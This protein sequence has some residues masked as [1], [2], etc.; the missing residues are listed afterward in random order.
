MKS[1]SRLLE[2]C[3]RPQAWNGINSVLRVGISARRR[4]QRPRLMLE[5]LEMRLA[6]A[7]FTVC[8]TLDDGSTH[9][10]RWAITQ[11]NADTD[12]TSLINFNIAASGVQ[13][14]LVG[15]SS[16]YA[17]QALPALTHPTT[18]DGTTEPGFATA[19]TPVIVLNGSQAGAVDG[20]DITG[21]NSTIKGL[22]I[23]QFQGSGLVLET[24]G[25]DRIQ[26]NYIGTNA[27]GTVALANTNG[28]A[29]YSNANTIGGTSAGAGN[30][31]SGNNNV[32]VGI[33]AA[34]ASGNLVQGNYIGTNASGTSAVPNAAYGVL[35]LAASGN[36][37]GGAVAGSGNVVSGN[38][39]IGVFLAGTGTTG[40]VVAGNDIG[41]NPNGTAALANAVYGVVIN[42]GASGNL[43]GGTTSG[44]GNVVSA[45]GQVGVFLSGTGTTGN[46][47]AGNDI[48]TNLNGTAALA[49]AAYGVAINGGA[50]DNTVGGTTPGAGDVVSGNG[51]VGV[52]LTGSGTTG[53]V[54][55]GNDIGTNL[56]G[57]AALP[58]AS[59]GVAINGGASG[60]LIGGSTAAARNVISGNSGTTGSGVII[61]G[62]GTTGNV[63]AA[64]WIGLNVDSH[65]NVIDGLG[66]GF[67]GVALVG[68][69]SGNWIGVNSAAGPGTENA[70]QGNVISGSYIGV[71]IS[72]TGTTANVVAG[73]QIGTDP[74]GTASVPNETYAAPSSYGVVIDVGAS[75]DLVGTSGQD[76]AVAD[77]LERNEIS[78]L[79]V[80]VLIYAQ[81]FATTG[82]VVAGN[83]IGTT[84]GGTAPLGNDSGVLVTVGASNNW[85]GLNPVYGP[86]N[87]DE[88][89]VISGNLGDGVALSGAGTSGNTV[90]GDYIGTNIAG[91]LAIANA[92]GVEVDTGA[93]GNTIGGT[94]AGAGNVISG[95]SGAGIL[96]N[97]SNNSINFSDN[98]STS[99]NY[100]NG[101]VTG[102]GWDG[103]LNPG[104]L[105]SGDAN[106]TAPGELT[107]SAVANAG[108]ENSLDNGPVLYKTVTG[109]F[110]V[111]V[112]VSSMTSVYYSDGGLIARI[113]ASAGNPEN[114][115]ALRCFGSGG[116]NATRNT[117][118][119]VTTNN[120]YPGLQPW[121]RLVRLGDVFS[122]YTK[123]AATDPWTLRDSVT[124][125]D[126]G[127][128]TP[129][130]VGLWFGTFLTGSIGSV[131][132]D[133]FT[134][135]SGI[136]SV[137]IR[138]NSID[139]NGGLGI[140]LGGSGVPVPNDSL[141]HNGPNNF[142]DFPVLILAASNATNTAV[143]GTFSSGNLPDGSPYQPDTTI[144]LDFYANTSPDPSGYGQ[145]QTFLG[146][147]QVQTDATG[148]VA[149]TTPSGVLAAPPAGESYVTA[150][151]TDPSGDTSEFSAD[152]PVSLDLPTVTVT[153]AGGA[154]T[155]SAFTAVGTAIGVD[156]TTP[157]A[158]NFSYT[159]Y[160]GSA[161][162]GTGSPTAPVNAG[163]Y[164]VVASFAS[165]DP[166]YSDG[167]SAP[168][169]F[170]IG[171][172]S[173]PLAVSDGGTYNG[174][175]FSAIAT[176]AGVDSA[177]SSSLE[178]VSLTLSY[179]AGTSAT[180]TPLAGPPTD[181][182]TYTLLASFAGSQDY[183]SASAQ[184]TFM[185]NPNTTL[186]PS[187]FVVT[188]PAD[189]GQQNIPS[190]DPTDTNGLVSLRS[191]IAAANFA[192]GDGVSDTITF[193]T[194]RIGTNM[195]VLQQGQLELTA[196]T[197]TTTINGGGQITVSGNNQYTVFTVDGG[198]NASFCGL[199]ITEGGGSG[200]GSGI[201]NSGTLT[202]S[203]S[204]LSDNFTSGNGGGIDN[205]YGATL[206]VSNSTLSDNSAPSGS[207]GGGIANFGTLTVTD[208]TLSDNSVGYGG[209]AI[210]NY[211]GQLTLI[212]STISGNNTAVEGGGIYSYSQA[213]SNATISGS[214]F[215]GNSSSDS[216]GGIYFANDG[217]GQLQVNNSTISGNTAAGQGGGIYC[218]YYSGPGGF[219]PMGVLS[220]TIVAG[221]TAADLA[222]GFLRN[223]H[224]LIG[225]DPGLAPLGD[226][227]GPTE[228][229]AL[230]P[231][232][233]ALGTGDPADTSADQ[234]GAPVDS[235]TPDIGAF[236]SQ[237]FNVNADITDP[238]YS[239]GQFGLTL[240]AVDG[241]GGN[242][243]AGFIYNIDWGDGTAQNPD[244]A[245][246]PAAA[247]NG[248]GVALSHVYANP[249]VYT[250][251]LTATDEGL[252]VSPPVTAIVVISTMA[253]DQIGI[254]GGSSPGQVAIATTDDG[255]LSTTA[256]PA[257][258]LVAGSGGNDAYTLNF[259]SNLTTPLTIA[260]SGT[261]TIT[262]NGS[263]DPSTSNYIVKSTGSQSTIT[264][265]PSSGPPAETVAYAGMQTTNVYGGAGTNYIA[266]PGSQTN[267]YG[268][269]GQNTIVIT[270]TAGSGVAIHGGGSDSYV[271]DLGNLAGPVTI[272]NSHTGAIDTLIVNGAPG[273]NAISVAGSQITEG[274]QTITVGAPLASLTVNGGS[275]NNQITVAA[276][277]VP[278]QNLAINGGGTGSSIT[279]NNIGTSVAFLAV[280]G[281][282]GS[283]ANVVQVLGSLPAT[284]TAQN[285]LPVVNAGTNATVNDGSTFSSSGSFADSSA[286]ATFS[287][288][289]NYGDGTAVQPLGLSANKTFTLS[290]VY[291][292]GGTYTVT[293]TVN[294]GHNG[295]GTGS[296]VVTVLNLPP[297]V[298]AISGA[299][300]VVPGQTAAL[301]ANFTDPGFLETHTATFNW[302]DNTISAGTV[303][304]SNGSGSVA[305][306]H[307]YATTGTYTV[308]LTVTN[309][310]GA[311]S[312]PVTF[313]ET[314]TQSDILLDA[315]AGGA[316]TISGNGSINIPGTLVV[317]SSSTSALSASGNA[318]VKARSIQ[319][320]GKVLKSGNA[321]L[322][323]AP[324]TGAA[325]VADP[326]ANLA[327]PSTTGMK[328][329]GAATV[330]GNSS[331]T[332]SPGIFTQITISG[333]ATVTLNAGVYLI[334]GG[335]FTV[336]GN[337]TVKGTGVLI[338]NAGSSYPSTGGTY[339]AISLSGNGAINLTAPATGMY[340]G[341]VF[342]QPSANAKAL[343]LSGNAVT[344]SGTVFAPSAQ[345]D[346]SGNAQLNAAI[347]VD[348]LVV[349][350]NGVSNGLA[351][352]APA[353]TVAY[354]PAQIRAAYG[355]NALGA[356][357]PALGAGLPTPPLDGT[358]Q[359][360]AIVDAYDDPSIGLALDTFD[361]QFGLTSSGPTLYSQYGPASSFLTV[362]NQYGLATS[363]PST[364]PNGPGTDNWEV[365]EALDVEW[366]H[367]IA[368]GAQIILVEANSQSLSDLMASVATA[369]GQ[370]GVSVVSMSWGFA[371]GQAVFA[372]D[373]A[374]YDSV[375]NVP[376]VT[377][378]AS[379]G[380]Y[381]A[382]DPEYP[383]FSPNVVAVGGTSLTLNADNS[384]NSETGWGYYSSS[385]GALIASGGGI[386]LY[387]PEP[388]YQQGVQSTG[389]RTTP[390][391]SFVADPATGA[392]I[393][394]PYNLD[395][396]NP[397][398]IV[399]GTSLSAPAWAGLAVLVNQGRV[400][401]GEL[402]LNSSSPTDTQQALYMLPQNDYNAITSGNNGYAASA[403]YNLVTGLGTPVAN[404]LVS[405]LIAYQGPGTTYSGPTVG[406]LQDANLV[407][408]GSS[409]GGPI[410]VF[411]VFDSIT[412]TNVGLSH[413]HAKGATRQE[414]ALGHMTNA[415]G[416]A[417]R[418]LTN[419]QRP[420]SS[421]ISSAAGDGLAQ[422]LTLPRQ[423][424]A[425]NSAVDQVLGVLVDTNSHDTLIGDLAFEQVT[426]L[427]KPRG[428]AA[429][430]TTS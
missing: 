394:D 367:A 221:N 272:S 125:P 27:A 255:S 185:I 236:Q 325:V 101:N 338:Y 304:E 150:T 208:S 90:A 29:I 46:V 308:T 10:L 239:S 36:T 216:G 385:V 428:S 188:D 146:S 218:R 30:V 350:G 273:N 25:G 204:T 224:C 136:T 147:Y 4:R 313:K 56:N 115:V 156:G 379:T 124:R 178:G 388:A 138:G 179:Y 161:A 373:E 296:F 423:A 324:I 137:S 348:T 191:A 205:N 340:A 395:P 43:I 186:V 402:S 35:V 28:I 67:A 258:V 419:L 21:G 393:S 175:P 7:T 48:G 311:S 81:G 134:L 270:A 151:A 22:V 263:T 406:P 354:T 291:G 108:W 269:P 229:M 143:T 249:G 349:S 287:A 398:E 192:A 261:D 429:T 69:A 153:D 220:N 68:G 176:V 63:V 202:V 92:T 250:V 142:Q 302:G 91:K 237:G 32:G 133:H 162:T 404:L 128:G 259:G 119:S 384:Y 289:V 94:T 112:H 283:G 199:T 389:G 290:H 210:G 339:G 360:I 189:V 335:G 328:N 274:T 1:R 424:T 45:N 84:A 104:S 358:G 78:G 251:S 317:D 50:S 213:G 72:G 383:A 109:D 316:L 97:T 212:N 118:N 380:D 80:G 382:A 327:G 88:R 374:A 65:G 359:T 378:I 222:G 245:S 24:N 19:G 33:F 114:Y 333:N 53:N 76:G 392:W 299:A 278:V 280:T 331:Q 391:V 346:L 154:Y 44:A 85:V 9:S 233:P 421:V 117:V 271:V 106:Q 244:T 54:V 254:S 122:F 414:T 187:I 260:G 347:I 79:G 410:D 246:V 243:A 180:G 70:L 292:K 356:G 47:V 297:S 157:V 247:D 369:A 74:S 390:D 277:S 155:G 342:V 120:N 38:G 223:D 334:E 105:L 190:D 430:G 131:Q 337:A 132:F 110:D 3:F 226:Y 298:G 26:G 286:T 366:A 416:R 312:T 96:V 158:G 343:T 319:V 172:A 326:F 171:Q 184:T 295:V 303:I 305:G 57:T 55:A 77:A 307:V 412:V 387:E 425:L 231:H 17:G 8:N 207:F 279:L 241:P 227:G 58:N 170:I 195:I 300:Q 73:N 168:L 276:L 165:A 167:A 322:S 11:A 198:A 183:T 362:L 422:P 49:N 194:T 368:P 160:V 217:Y 409:D 284:V 318:T 141:G 293:V 285:V 364:D 315:T 400:A 314:V 426:S 52:F 281:G 166:T 288:T 357:L 181:P 130:Q 149:F 427:R 361:A 294:D 31:I 377:F 321:T 408:T 403:G 14:I 200:S 235:P 371:E 177:P 332:L 64:N 87:A 173:A 5:Q 268:G 214:T 174:S 100:A 98:F 197:G 407:N 396:S 196:G 353:G 15:S 420:A 256:T 12:P 267:I 262:V 329:Y 417:D 240:S 89:N 413:A 386:S 182:G 135:E 148:Y 215:S 242:Q 330:S 275:G 18:I 345:L 253:S 13:T 75:S 139:D 252:E 232:S 145:G 228:T 164:T 265:G 60:N 102:T 375:F 59:Y 282:S 127:S 34:A 370:P 144:T 169:T 93:S 415:A 121:L 23:Q 219:G 234:R 264:W 418:P 372:A 103:V 381:G 248:S 352:T 39:Q 411:S 116:F 140:D 61:G 82:N 99:H 320:V 193:N 113:A 42:A 206:T 266:D 351:P 201:L 365:E 405:D 401:A 37:I 203:N 238:T 309:S 310:E 71:T 209:G 51:A 126:I 211:D 306:S 41:T 62:A 341:L 6:P 230:L 225:G 257:Q 152:L 86:E 159:Y 344:L 363:L 397:F 123:A 399:G 95:N 2:H 323:P 83:Y 336:S 163:T 129:M 107:W 16:A 40:N 20:L 355:I 111:S 376:G 301:T 66:D